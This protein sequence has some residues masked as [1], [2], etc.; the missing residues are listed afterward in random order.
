[1]LMLFSA[2]PTAGY[3][4]AL[5]ALFV[6]L[7]SPITVFP[8]GDTVTL[9]GP[10]DPYPPDSIWVLPNQ[11]SA[12]C[13]FGTASVAQKPTYSILPFWFSIGVYPYIRIS[14][15]SVNLSLLPPHRIR[16]LA[17]FPNSIYKLR[18]DTVY[19]TAPFGNAQGVQHYSRIVTREAQPYSQRVTFIVS[20]AS[21]AG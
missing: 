15:S 16:T 3:A 7:S 8:G 11:Y 21:L 1:M 10:A 18:H 4:V 12:S 20:R 17:Y 9:L 14:H 5:L 2:L 19:G 6:D 13:H